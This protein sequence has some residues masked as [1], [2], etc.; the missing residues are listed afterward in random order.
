MRGAL[1]MFISQS[2]IY[3]HGFYHRHARAHTLVGVVIRICSLELIEISLSLLEKYKVFFFFQYLPRKV[4]ISYGSGPLQLL[5]L[6]R[7]LFLS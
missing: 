5:L 4:Y 7:L 2:S 1:E 6:L 3:I